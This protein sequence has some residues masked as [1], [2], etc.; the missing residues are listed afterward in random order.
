MWAWP[1][2]I[3]LTQTVPERIAW[4]KLAC[5]TEESETAKPAA[6]PRVSDVGVRPIITC[7]HAFVT[8]AGGV[9]PRACGVHHAAQVGNDVARDSSP[10]ASGSKDPAIDATR[11]ARASDK[12][13]RDP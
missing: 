1:A 4:T 3:V 11:P 6:R 5:A 7:A 8:C 12:R 9:A 10:A 2:R 13:A